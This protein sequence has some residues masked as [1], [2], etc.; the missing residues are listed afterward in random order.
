MHHESS[1]VA[2]LEDT[3]AGLLDSSP[4]WRTQDQAH[5]K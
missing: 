5:G 3:L 1:A 2:S 4:S